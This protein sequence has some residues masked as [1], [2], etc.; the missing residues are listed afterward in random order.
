M[1][2]MINRG[3]MRRAREVTTVLVRSSGSLMK[4]TMKMKTGEGGVGMKEVVGFF[5]GRNT[6]PPS[7]EGEKVTQNF[8]V[9]CPGASHQL[10]L[11]ESIEQW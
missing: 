7:F 1:S 2:L 11:S 6:N 3:T 8:L 10:A 5:P 9:Y 4:K